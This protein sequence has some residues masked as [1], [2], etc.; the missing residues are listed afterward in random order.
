MS[1]GWCGSVDWVPAWEQKGHLL[2]SWSGHMLG[3]RARSPVG[4]MREATN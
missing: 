1:P 4:G 2:D 3:L